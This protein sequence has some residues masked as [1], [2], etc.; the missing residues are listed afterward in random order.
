MD[1]VTSTRPARLSEVAPSGLMGLTR[2]R[3]CLNA[4]AQLSYAASDEYSAA[5]LREAGTAYTANPN[6]NPDP[7]PNRA[8]R[9][10][11]RVL[12]RWYYRAHEAR[13]PHQHRLYTNERAT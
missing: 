2:V 11:H 6:P 1:L 9:G 13:T 8:A 3:Y 12:L 7:N 10:W 5:G 4:A